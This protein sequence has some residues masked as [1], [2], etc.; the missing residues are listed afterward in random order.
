MSTRSI[1]ALFVAAAVSSAA[2]LIFSGCAPQVSP[3]LRAASLS[4]PRAAEIWGEK[5][6]SC[7]VPVEPGSRPR[8][9]IQAAMERH[10]KRAKL[11]SAEWNEL[12]EFLAHTPE[13]TADNRSH[14]ASS[15][16]RA[17]R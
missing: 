4:H 3:E 8:P 13:R 6:G 5:C 11:T 17:P 15:A 9:L 10:Q 16:D 7:H 1:F 2:T 12:V 14:G